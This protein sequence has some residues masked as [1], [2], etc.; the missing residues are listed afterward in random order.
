VE[1]SLASGILESK[2]RDTLQDLDKLFLTKLLEWGKERFVAML[3]ELDATLRRVRE[4]TLRVV[5]QRPVWY[6]TCLGTVRVLRT[7]YR[8]RDG[9]Y[10]YLLD[11]A[12]GMGSRRHITPQLSGMALK[13]AVETTFRR[14]ARFLQ[15][16]T[17]ASLSHQT[18]HNQVARV[19]DPYLR[20]QDQEAGDFLQ[21]GVLP[22]SEGGKVSRLMV[23]ADGVVL[24]L[25]REHARKSEVK[26]GIAYEGWAKVG[27]DRYRTVNKTFFADTGDGHR[28]WAGMMVKLQK[29]YDM[30]GVTEVIAGGDG[31][32]WIRD[33]ADDLGARFQLCRYHL[34]RALCHALGR[35]RDIIR[36]VRAAC[37]Q[38]RADL[39]DAILAQAGAGST[40]EETGRI[41]SVRA[42]IAENAS[43]L[44]DYRLS[45]GG[46]GKGLRRPGAIEGNIDKL[47][48]RRMKNQG[49]SWRVIGIRRLI[50]VRFLYLEGRLDQWLHRAT[51]L[52]VPATSRRK[53]ERKVK[54]WLKYPA[55]T[56]WQDGGLP[57]L[58]GPHASRPW[59]MRL[60]ELARIPA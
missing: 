38:G 35:R 7:C 8:G 11:E 31:A 32:P 6:R 20:Q 5:R 55:Y 14:A 60:R 30:A 18:I 48:V 39:A 29:R 46:E 27:R 19:A 33:G 53:F 21:A 25:Q 42:Y 16:L 34:N 52:A 57:A 49:M 1:S 22:D 45:L 23:E 9:K 15:E 47:L 43:G 37:Q 3:E 50:C 58:S 17:A 28:Q 36:A 4:K 40:G 10:R 41:E 44:G 56:A 59:A 26:L 51:V 13:L 54:R 24:S 12:L 2:G